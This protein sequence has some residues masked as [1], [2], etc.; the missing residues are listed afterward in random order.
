MPLSAQAR[1]HRADLAEL[2]RLAENDLSIVFRDVGNAVAVR[3]ELEDYLP[4]LVAM[5]GSAAASLGAYWYDD[6]R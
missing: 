6:M 4:K 2:A 5:Y 3:D 1:R